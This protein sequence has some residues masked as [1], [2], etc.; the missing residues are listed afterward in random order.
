MPN[1]QRSWGGG[2]GTYYN[3]TPLL[4]VPGSERTEFMTVTNANMLVMGQLET[5]RAF[6]NLDAI[7][8]V[9]GIDA[10]A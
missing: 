9:S 5:T 4:D 7:L 3:S 10:F 8:E 6:E 1:G 2:R